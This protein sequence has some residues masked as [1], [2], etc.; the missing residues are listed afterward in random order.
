MTKHHHTKEYYKKIHSAKP[1]TPIALQTTTAKS[2]K[3][4]TSNLFVLS[5]TPPTVEAT[6]N[7][8]FE[9]LV[10]TELSSYVSH[11]MVKGQ[12]I[13]Y[14]PITNLAGISQQYSPLNIIRL[15]GTSAQTIYNYD[16]SLESYL[17][18][19]GYGTNGEIVY[20]DL[21]NN[22]AVLNFINLSEN[23]RVEIEFLTYDSLR[24]DTIYK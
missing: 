20:I 15:Q 10:A 8:I 18:H 19:V 16:Y 22:N 9:S 2:I 17:P 1:H 3:I 21:T 23:D 11:D 12:N 14:Q 24:S 4:A 6:F 7:L 5:D 13:A